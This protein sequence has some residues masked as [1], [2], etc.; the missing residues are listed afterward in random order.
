[1]VAACDLYDGRLEDAKRIYGKDI[2]TTRDFREVLSRKDIDA[3]IIATPDHWHKD[4]SVAA[5]NAGKSV[6]CEKPMTQN[7]SE[8][9]AVVEAQNRNK[10]VF[11][12]GSQ[13]VSSLGNEKAK[14]TSCCRSHRSAQLC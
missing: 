9:S 7:V 3:V 12:V 8:G 5:M 6:Y 2:F 10:V 14:G 13:G 11:Q 4:I 1:M